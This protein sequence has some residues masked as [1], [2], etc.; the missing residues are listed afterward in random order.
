MNYEFEKQSGTDNGKRDDGV[1]IPFEV[2]KA[3]ALNGIPL[4]RAWREHLGLTQ[5]EVA[6]RSG[7]NQTAYAEF[8]RPDARP[9]H[10][11]LRKI[12]DAMGLKVE[13]I[14]D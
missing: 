13:Q 7:M 1:W 14:A 5:R 9:R 4:L 3:N 12:A 10:A 6:E 11:T 8:E 2:V